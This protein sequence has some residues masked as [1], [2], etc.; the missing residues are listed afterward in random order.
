MTNTQTN[1]AQQL[2][3]STTARVLPPTIEGGLAAAGVAVD[4]IDTGGVVNAA[5]SVAVVNVHLAP[6]AAEAG[7]T[8][9]SVGDIIS[10]PYHYCCYVLRFLYLRA[11]LLYLNTN[12]F[13]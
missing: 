7:H 11:H 3:A 5:V 10:P 6:V 2:E 1:K 8:V 4:A 12:V 13:A 9:T